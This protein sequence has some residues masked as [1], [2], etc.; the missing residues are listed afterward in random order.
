MKK[1]CIITFLAFTLTILPVFSASWEI[2]DARNYYA[3]G[4]YSQALKSISS[5]ISG[6]NSNDPIAYN[7]RAKIYQKMNSPISAINDLT[8]ELEILTKGE[9][10]NNETVKQIFEALNTRGDLYLKTN[11]YQNAID[12]Y[13]KIFKYSPNKNMINIVEKNLKKIVNNKDIPAGYRI[14][15]AS[16]IS[17]I[18]DG[19]YGVDSIETIATIMKIIQIGA[20]A[21][22]NDILFKNSSKE[23]M[24]KT[25]RER[26][27]EFYTSI[28]NQNREHLLGGE[29][30]HGES[31]YAMGNK[32]LGLKII[33][34]ALN[35][36]KS[37]ENINTYNSAKSDVD[38]V[39]KVLNTGL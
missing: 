23:E 15:S 34:G 8:K 14:T 35:E 37:T 29:I 12:D 18:Y 27:D 22:E 21:N 3:N 2:Q 31:E 32:E 30:A 13:I 36:I 11:N 24:L 4:Q 19:L 10:P 7:L 28:K 16:Y 26:I 20:N 17:Q 9:S 38:Y 6:I 5:A 39:L 25:C 33:N 1:L